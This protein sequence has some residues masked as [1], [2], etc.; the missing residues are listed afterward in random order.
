MRNSEEVAFPI[1]VS[2][3]SSSALRLSLLDRSGVSIVC[4]RLLGIL[5]SKIFPPQLCEVLPKFFYR[6]DSYGAADASTRHT[7]PP[8]LTHPQPAPERPRAQTSSRHSERVPAQSG[9]AC[10]QTA[11]GPR[12]G[13]QGCV[14]GMWERAA[15]CSV[16]RAP[17]DP[18]HTRWWRHAGARGVRFCLGRP[19]LTLCTPHPQGPPCPWTR[20]SPRLARRR[21]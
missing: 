10:R 5:V 6:R 2:H 7:L 11:Q 14:G 3:S 19:L 17:P 12:W 9:A 15:S 8:T 18:L 16:S 13:A 20:A 21:T 4:N 1:C